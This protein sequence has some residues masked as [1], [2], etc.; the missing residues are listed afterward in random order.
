[1]GIIALD[2]IYTP[3]K[4]VN[5][6]IENMRVGKRTDFERINLVVTTDGSVNPQ[7]AF[8]KAV[9]I[10]VEQF[11]V[12]KKLDESK[13]KEEVVEEKEEIVEEVKEEIAE[14]P[15]EVLVATLKSLSTRTLNVLEKG[16]IK[17]LGGILKLTEDQ[18]KDLEGMGDKGVKEIKKA[19][20]DYGFNLKK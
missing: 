1:V 20:G 4:R 6:T 3:I 11:G 15:K 17:N 7:E 16:K 5:Y 12:L 8:S 14:D 10:L 2:A 19:I 9:N 18:L 13:E